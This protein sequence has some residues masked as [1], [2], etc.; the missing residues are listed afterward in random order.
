MVTFIMVCMTCWV[1]C[2]PSNRVWLQYCSWI[3][4]GGDRDLTLLKNATTA[5]T[6]VKQAC[7]SYIC[8]KDL[9]MNPLQSHGFGGETFIAAW[10]PYHP[11]DMVGICWWVVHTLCVWK[12]WNQVLRCWSRMYVGRSKGRVTLTRSFLTS[13]DPPSNGP[14]STSKLLAIDECLDHCLVNCS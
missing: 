7:S 5:T 1:S 14:N 11:V 2:T 13:Q 9:R 4:S 10:I 6:L 12:N 8:S 3:G